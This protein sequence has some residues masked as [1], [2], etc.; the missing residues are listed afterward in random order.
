MKKHL[1]QNNTILSVT[2]EMNNGYILLETCSYKQISEDDDYSDLIGPLKILKTLYE[3]PILF[4]VGSKENFNFPE[5]QV[6]LWDDRIKTKLGIIFMQ[7]E[8]IDLQVRKEA[9]FVMSNSKILIFSTLSLELVC[10]IQDVNCS[11]PLEISYTHNPIVLSY[12]SPGK[13]NQV[14]ITKIKYDSNFKLDGKLQYVITTLFKQITR[15][16]VSERV[17]IKL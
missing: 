12:M 15:Y 13:E 1:N 4:F 2:D 17:I 5:N 16:T 10:Q 14:K 6:V 11:H 9:L 7:N 8:V 3:S